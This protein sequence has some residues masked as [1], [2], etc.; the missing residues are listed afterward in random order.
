M[1]QTI[2]ELGRRISS[3]RKC[4]SMN[5]GQRRVQGVG[6]DASV[7]IVGESPGR[8]GADLTGVPFTQDRSGKLLRSM[9]ESVGLSQ[10]VYIT[11]VVKCNARDKQGRNRSPSRKEIENCREYLKAEL[12]LV[13][14]KVIVPLGR[15]AAREFVDFK[16]RMSE[17]N[18]RIFSHRIYGSI[19]P[20]YH[21]GYIIR[22][23][24]S[25]TLYT[26]DFRDLKKLIETK[27][28]VL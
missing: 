16:F 6:I 19:F 21:P 9:I 3:C 11:N 1:F 14:A 10:D 22:G 15:T 4:E 20:L 25:E 8:F 2:D 26:K 7:C 23:N 28:K 12:D 17:I 24:Y 18:A 5:Q 27:N 13:K